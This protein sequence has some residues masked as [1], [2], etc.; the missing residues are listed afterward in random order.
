MKAISKIL[1]GVELPEPNRASLDEAVLLARSLGAEV[2][3]LHALSERGPCSDEVRARLDELEAEL[4]AAGVRVGPSMFPRAAPAEAIGRAIV[5]TR[6]DLV[7]LGAAAKTTL[8]RLLLGSTAEEVVRTAP[9][10]VWLTRTFGRHAAIRSIA[11]AVD[12]SAPARE[13]LASAVF[14]ARLFVAK[15]L[16]VSVVPPAEARGALKTTER[17]FRETLAGIDLHGVDHEVVLHVG[18]PAVGIAK[19]TAERRPDLLVLGAARRRGLARMVLGNTSEAVLRQVPCSV[20][21]VPAV[22]ATERPPLD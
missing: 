5:E 22:G 7:A 8:D 9:V 11:C 12:A 6:P 13:A 17:A 4:V 20:L 21:T 1:V 18:P 10:P 2:T 16:L 14:L 19:V 15:L 3:L